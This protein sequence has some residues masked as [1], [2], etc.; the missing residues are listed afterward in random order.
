MKPVTGSVWVLVMVVMALV[1]LSVSAVICRADQVIITG[2]ILSGGRLEGDD[3]ITYRIGTI[4]KG[5]ELSMKQGKR[6]EV[7]GTVLD[8]EGY[9]PVIDVMEYKVK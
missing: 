8:N 7:K 5:N 9:R 1:V 4:D 2:T 6:V 3:G